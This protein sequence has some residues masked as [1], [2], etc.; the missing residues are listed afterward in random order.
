[1]SPPL[2]LWGLGSIGVFASRAFLPAL[3]TAPLL[4]FGPQIPWLALA[5]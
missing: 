5:P 1:M 4:R 3:V 2:L